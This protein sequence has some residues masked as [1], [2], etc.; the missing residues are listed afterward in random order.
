MINSNETS[1]TSLVNHKRMN[2]AF[3]KKS[4]L[5][6]KKMTNN[7]NF[8]AKKNEKI[9]LFLADVGT[10]FLK[11]KKSTVLVASCAS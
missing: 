5:Q 9:C 3:F 8:D 7:E 11:Q 4:R 6:R 1:E 2:F 10:M